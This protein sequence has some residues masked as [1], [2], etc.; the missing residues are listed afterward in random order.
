MRRLLALGVLLAGCGSGADAPSPEVEPV[1][2]EPAAEPEAPPPF[3]VDVDAVSLGPALRARPERALLVNVWSTWCEPCVEEMPGLIG[4]ARSYEDRGLGLVLIAT[5]APA[6]REEAEAF[7]ITQGAPRPSWFKVGP[8]DPFIRALHPDWS[9]GLP[10][11]LLLDDQRRV[12]HFWEEPVSADTLREPIE[13]LL[14]D[15]HP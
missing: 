11:T 5:D 1:E 13:S 3:W 15:T 9:G 6:S 12:A 4:T 8:D 10:A 2:A 14:G 7:L